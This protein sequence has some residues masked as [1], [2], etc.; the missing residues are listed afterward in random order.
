MASVEE[1]WH[2]SGDSDIATCM[3]I[4]MRICRM[5]FFKSCSLTFEMFWREFECREVLG[6]W[7]VLRI[8]ANLVPEGST[9]RL[10]NWVIAGH[11]AHFSA[12]CA[13]C[14]LAFSGCAICN[15]Q[16]THTSISFLCCKRGNAVNFFAESWFPTY[17]TTAFILT[18]APL[19][20]KSTPKTSRKGWNLSDGHITGKIYCL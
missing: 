6:V 10:W 14:N 12:A 13:I 15:L 18:K 11:A 17:I 7:F 1:N 5:K 19:L 9:S 16:N 4:P 2:T 20:W 8:S 3:H